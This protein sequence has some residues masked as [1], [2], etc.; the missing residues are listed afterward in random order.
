MNRIYQ[1]R[2]TRVELL[3][4][5]NGQPQPLAD[6][7]EI[8]WQHHELFQDAVN[9]YVVCLLALAGPRNESLWQLRRRLNATVTDADGHPQ[10]DDLMVWRP[11]RRRGVLRSGMR[12]SVAPYLCPGQPDATPEDCFAAV[13]KGNECAQTEEGRA[14]LSEGLAQLLAK[15][16]GDSR[17][18][19]A[20]PVFL[21]RFAKPDYKGNYGADTT[22]LLREDH[23][24]R[25]PFVIHNPQTRADSP[26]LDEFGV[27]SIA[28]PNEKKPRFA[29]EEAIKKLK[30][31]VNEWRKR[32]PESSADWKRLESAIAKLETSIEIPGY[33]G[34]SAKG[35]QE[36]SRDKQLRLFAMFLFKYV[37]RSE[38]TLGLLR[39][40]T[41]KPNPEE[42]PPVPVSRQLSGGDPIRIARGSRGYVFRAFTSLPCWGGNDSG[43][44]QWIEFDFAAFEEALKALHQVDAKAEERR[45]ER[46]KKQ[47][48]HDYQ[49]GKTTKWKSTSE[50]STPPPVLVG[51]PRIKRLEE[52]LSGDLAEEYEMSEG[53]SVEYGLQQ[54]TIR[55]FRELRKKW[56]EILA[57]ND[58][59]DYSPALYDE[60]KQK[61]RDFQKEN[62]TIVGSVRLFEAL[63]E[64]D[65]WLIWREPTADEMNQWRK[66]AGLPKDVQ[67]APDPLQALTDE[68]E[69]LHDIDR[70]SGPIRFTPAHPE[71]SRRQ[72]Y[73]SDVTDLTAKNRLRHNRQTVDVEL[74]VKEDGVWRKKEV[75]LHF[76]APRLLRDQLNNASGKDAVFQQAMMEALGISSRLTALKKKQVVEGFE[77][78]AAVALMPE[79][80]NDGS[81]RI[82]LNFPLTLDGESIAGQLG[83]AERWHDLQFGGADG[84]SYWLRWPKTWIDEKK[85]RKKAPPAPWWTNPQP[86]QVLSV[87]LGQRDAGAF[88]L[89]EATPGD[90]PKPQSRKLGEA[91]DKTWW[92]TVKAT[93]VLHLPGEDAKLRRDRT[94]FDEEDDDAKELEELSGIAGAWPR[95]PSGRKPA[96]FASS[97]VCLPT[98]CWARSVGDIPSPNSTTN[99][100]M[101]STAPSNASRVCKAGVAW[102]GR[103]RTRSSRRSSRNAGQE[104]KNRS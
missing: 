93:G 75:R 17:C 44:P 97:W 18:K 9:Y 102:P 15:C 70:L 72:F 66:D 31:M 45:K 54:R 48:Q 59:R 51:D 46:E 32:Q 37:E 77:H 56:L 80:R 28:L 71:H 52:L 4:G 91:G 65:N 90:R 42:H 101:R 27:H 67:F 19:Q 55:G 5:A 98:R 84:E 13:L 47:A 87:D 100:Y 57:K 11:F 34:A 2:V 40:T 6:W 14:R 96:T 22:T 20:A 53:I 89:I 33:A 1:G 8:L 88:A 50:D 7:P 103:K 49:R 10:D 60:L 95:R 61:L 35:S 21:P 63:L 86:F 83:K 29:G 78:C 43:K 73:F 94:A 92:A 104:S 26:E 64:K 74:A 82:L 76:S 69:L 36:L 30:S 25:L 16:T 79:V 62:P 68:R 12:D 41:P 24:A 81:K 58:T 38:F 99:C 3:P 85:E 23:A 39:A